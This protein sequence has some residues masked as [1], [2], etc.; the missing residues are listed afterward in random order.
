MVTLYLSPTDKKS[1]ST[2]VD[3]TTIGPASVL[4]TKASSASFIPQF[5]SGAVVSKTASGDKTP[6]TDQSGK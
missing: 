1:E 4:F 6:E 3:T 5:V 2:V